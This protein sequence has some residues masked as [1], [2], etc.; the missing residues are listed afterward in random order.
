MV[1]NITFQAE[2]AESSHI[3][4]FMDPFSTEV[5]RNIIITSVIVAIY[6]SLLNKLSPYDY[7]GEFMYIDYEEQLKL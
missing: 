5:W 3:F 1:T 2:A 6:V 4:T 7:H